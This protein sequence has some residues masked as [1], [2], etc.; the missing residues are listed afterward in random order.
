LSDGS[1]VNPTT[2]TTTTSPSSNGTVVPGAGWKTTRY[3]VVNGMI[4]YPPSNLDTNT[5]I[6]DLVMGIIVEHKNNNPTAAWNFTPV[7]IR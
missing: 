6:N 2:F 7:R 3:E 4:I 1:Y 5:T